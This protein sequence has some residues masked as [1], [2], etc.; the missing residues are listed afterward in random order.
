MKRLPRGELEA[1]VMDLLW[2]APGWMTPSEVH[3]E[4]TTPRRPLA[5]TTVTTILVRLWAK[6]MLEREASGRAFSYRPVASRDE[7]AAQRMQEILE[8]SGD[9][10]VTLNHFVDSIS[11]REISQLRRVLD[12]R[13]KR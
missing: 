1:Q 5:Y 12:A 2:D 13:R 11:A 4:I 9:R 8:A 3:Q 6:G 7:W 10:R